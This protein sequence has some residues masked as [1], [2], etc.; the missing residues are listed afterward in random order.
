MWSTLIEKKS[1]YFRALQIVYKNFPQY[2]YYL[3]ISILLVFILTIITSLIPWLMGLVVNAFTS[4]S[5]HLM[6]IIFIFLGA[7]LFHHIGRFTSN[8]IGIYST[9]RSDAAMTA[10]FIEQIIMSQYETQAKIDLGV[11]ISEWQRYKI[12]FTTINNILLLTI[13]PIIIEITVIFTIISQWISTLFAS[14]IAAGLVSLFVLAYFLSE[15]KKKHYAQQFSANNRL[16]SF[17]TNRLSLLYESALN[18]ARDDDI[19]DLKI[20]TD[21]YSQH[22]IFHS[23]RLMLVN[24]FMMISTWVFLSFCIVWLVFIESGTAGEFVA[25]ATYIL[26]I[27]NPFISA[28]QQL[29]QLNG[30][31]IA[32]QQGLK[33]FDFPLEDHPI[34]SINLMHD[35]IYSFDK[36]KISKFFIEKEIINSKSITLIRGESGL[37]KT[38]FLNALCGLYRNYQGNILFCGEN[39]SKI[40]S[41]NI[42]KNIAIVSQHPSFISAN[43]RENLLW[44]NSDKNIDHE[45][46]E[47]LLL[48]LNLSHLLARDIL[49]NHELSGGEKQRLAIARIILKNKTIAILDEP[50]SALDDNNRENLLKILKK[51]IPT[52]IIFSHDEM[53]LAHADKIIDLDKLLI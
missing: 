52:L 1:L 34:K 39:L 40:N 14:I 37:G 25:V 27:T 15:Y 6:L 4:E 30:Q 29:S 22:V 42:I 44:G 33:Y 21:C 23:S 12:S 41:N 49:L 20:E 10:S 43:V 50:T 45:R 48:E 2:G 7:E 46:I 16:Y 24:F 13:L 38:T 26:R 11:L 8:L 35:P 3:F 47:S 19:N 9:T 32:L 51:Y 36:L 28:S 18:H 31:F 5:S 17:L 53:L